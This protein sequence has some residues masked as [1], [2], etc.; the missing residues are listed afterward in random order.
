MSVGQPG[1][2]VPFHIHAMPVTS[3]FK[4]DSFSEKLRLHR[5]KTRCFGF[6]QL[7]RRARGLPCFGLRALISAITRAPE[8]ARIL[9]PF[10]APSRAPVFDEKGPSFSPLEW[11]THPGVGDVISR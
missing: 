11:H 1:E 2:A 6:T 4:D 5:T 10:R 8:R 9:R 7:P 3:H